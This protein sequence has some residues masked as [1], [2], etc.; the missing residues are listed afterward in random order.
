MEHVFDK[1]LRADK[2]KTMWC[3]GCGNGIVLQALIRALDESGAIR[4]RWW[5][6][7]AWAAPAGR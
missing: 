7:P 6:F 2:L 5:W 1:Y 4:T 3:P